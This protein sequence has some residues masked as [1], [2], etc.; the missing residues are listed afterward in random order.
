MS[1]AEKPHLY[2][3]GPI[4]AIRLEGKIGQTKKVIELFLSWPTDPSD[5]TKCDDIRAV[6]INTYLVREFD[7]AFKLQPK[8]IYDFVYGRG[9]LSPDFNPKIRGTYDNRVA[10]I[11]AKSFEID[12]DENK[13][14]VSSLVPNVRFHYVS[15]LDYVFRKSNHVLN[16][17]QSIVN[18]I[19][20]SRTYK[21]DDLTKLHNNIIL[22]GDE[23]MRIH[24]LFFVESVPNPKMAKSVY[25]AT[26]N[27]VFDIAED[28]IN[29]LIE[30]LIYK[31]KNSYENKSVGETM[32]KIINTEFKELLQSYIAEEKK[33]L[34][35]IG[36]E[37]EFLKKLG[38]HNLGDI[39]LQQH[40][41]TYE[42]NPDP[43]AM[44]EKVLFFKNIPRIL[45][46]YVY[47][48]IGSFLENA[49]SSED[50]AW[51]K[52]ILRI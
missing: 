9:P 19:W 5:Q 14:K 38:D 31:L 40:D 7:S 17:I 20:R 15:V 29:K 48:L 33:I 42:Y 51:I 43:S 18:N 34:D 11:F 32:S 24:K 44:N 39:L 16:D 4:N 30:K 22:V 3:N 37:I 13:V 41:G 25:S 52:N 26:I 23:I 8:K 28:D 50:D 35:T 27:T 21:L 12:P 36:L 45:E 47:D 2:I 10:E 6:D 49:N 1:S 46:E